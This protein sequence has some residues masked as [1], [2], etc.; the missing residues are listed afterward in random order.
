[1]TG[2]WRVAAALLL[3]TSARADVELVV[4]GPGDAMWSRFG[5]VF[6]R[7]GDR[8]YN[9][10]STPRYDPAFARDYLCGRARFRVVAES[11]TG[12][13]RRSAMRDR[14][15]WTRP[16]LLNDTELA[17][18]ADDLARAVAPGN[19]D[20]LYEHQHDNCVTRLRDILDRATG[21]ALRRPGLR[22]GTYRDATLAHL[23]GA[24]GPQICADLIAGSPQDVEPEPWEWCYLPE[25]LDEVVAAATRADGSRIAGA[26]C[27]RHVRR[28]P[29]VQDG[30]PYRGRIVLGLSA[31]TVALALLVSRRAGGACLLLAAPLFAAAGLLLWALPAISSVRDYAWSDNALL[32][33]P[34]DVIL[35]GVAWRRVCGRPGLTSFARRYLLARLGVTACYVGAKLAGAFPQDNWTFVGAAALVLLAARVDR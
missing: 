13:M 15:V 23:A 31:V 18:L 21:G 28:A 10:A 12:A 8:C 30:S 6:L 14:S 29:P 27:A 7:V 9:F 19:R 2:L 17:R 1:M 35:V 33:W 11:W 20:Y 22:G 32:F 24:L 34:C 26:R 3:G 16:L 4:L 5:H 25:R